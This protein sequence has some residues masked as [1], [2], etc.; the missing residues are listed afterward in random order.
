MSS[1]VKKNKETA[2]FADSEIGKV[3]IKKKT[4]VAKY[5]S[6][7]ELK[8]VFKKHVQ[9]F[10]MLRSEMIH[11]QQCVKISVEN[12]FVNNENGD[13]VRKELNF[14]F[15]FVLL[16]KYKTELEMLKNHFE[17]LRFADLMVKTF[18]KSMVG[19]VSQSD[20]EMDSDVAK[21]FFAFKN[22]QAKG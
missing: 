19:K 10:F 11:A 1:K 5:K 6:V 7:E 12:S 21:Y 20:S 2:L 15:L 16:E 22:Q 3:P 18:E 14:D 9:L 4:D 13:S 17:E 8:K